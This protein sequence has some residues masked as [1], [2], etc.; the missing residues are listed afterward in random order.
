MVQFNNTKCYYMYKLDD[1]FTFR[2][3][4]SVIGIRRWFSKFTKGCVLIESIPYIG[5]SSYIA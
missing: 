5:V 2:V 4:A 3:K 1:T